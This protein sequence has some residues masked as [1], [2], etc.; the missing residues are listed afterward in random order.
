MG[1]ALPAVEIERQHPV[2]KE[3]SMEARAWCGNSCQTGRATHGP[4]IFMQV[5]V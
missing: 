1:H 2:S 3:C 4:L 5:P